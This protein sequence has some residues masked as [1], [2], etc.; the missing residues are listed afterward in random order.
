MMVVRIESFF[1]QIAEPPANLL[2]GFVLRIENK[3]GHKNY[4]VEP[5]FFV[6]PSSSTLFKSVPN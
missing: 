3:K 5:F 6:R 4:T 1:S 2:L